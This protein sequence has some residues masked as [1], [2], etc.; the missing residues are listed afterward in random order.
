MF[1]KEAAA[2]VRTQTRPD[3]RAPLVGVW[4][5]QA[6]RRDGRALEGPVPRACILFTPKGR[7]MALAT[8]TRGAGGAAER[9]GGAG[10]FRAAFAYSGAYRVVGNAWITAR[11]RS[12]SELPALGEEIHFFEIE[13][14]TLRVRAGREE[15]AFRRMM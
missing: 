6:V 9:G 11:R 13:G 3:E 14:A 7:F 4:E 15:F 8:A 12:W 2:G 10:A 5:L 1:E